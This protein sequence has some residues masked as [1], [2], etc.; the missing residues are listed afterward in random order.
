MRNAVM[1]PNESIIALTAWGMMTV[2]IPEP[3]A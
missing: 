1:I 2:A 3:A